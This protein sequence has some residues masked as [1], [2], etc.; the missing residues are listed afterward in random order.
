MTEYS[1]REPEGYSQAPTSGLESQRTG[2]DKPPSPPG[3][4]PIPTPLLRPK[5]K[6]DAFPSSAFGPLEPAAAA[7]A[8]ITRAPFGLAAQ[9]VLAAASLA[10][11]AH[12]N[13]ETLDAPKPLSLFLVSVAESGER[14]TACDRLAL[15]GIRRFEEAREDRFAASY[16][17]YRDE[18]EVFE[19][20]RRSILGKRQDA[21]AQKAD[22]HD[23]GGEP[24]C[25]AA[26]QLLLDDPTMEGLLKHFETSQPSLGI[27]SDEGGQ[28]LCGHGMNADNRIKM[29]T[30]LS[31]LWGGGSINRTRAGTGPSRT[32]RNR[33][34]ACHLMV[35]PRLVEHF[36][37]DESLRDQGLLSRMLLAWPSS[38]I[39]G[40]FLP[41]DRRPD[42]S[43]QERDLGKFNDRIV[44]LMELG[45]PEGPP[46]QLR[47]RDLPLSGEAYE[48]LVD[49]HNHVEPLQR[50][51]APLQNI[52]G[53][54]SK[55]VEQ[56]AR[57]AGV[58]QVFQDQNAPE[59]TAANMANAIELMGWYLGEARRLLEVA[60][61]PAQVKQAEMLRQWLLSSW[62]EDYIDVR[63]IVRRGPSQLRSS[64]KARQAVRLLEED[65]W[66]L[67]APGPRKIDGARANTSWRI[68]RG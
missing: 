28:F 10:G 51:D 55:S 6:A 18:L 33:R 52:R 67:P 24:Q 12:C 17:A 50:Q 68:I 21:T 43:D 47:L 31:T 34:L 25:P 62:Q 40:R 41:S 58:M 38:N 22:L 15:D 44:A 30:A 42:Y 65:L 4:D 61:V 46:R 57:I 39:G 8:E 26:S 49:F 56:A 48:L 35:Q 5:E 45:L 14:K 60:A 2:N 37:A 32:F 16:A 13:V 53:F 23:L 1:G 54:A 59:L 3:S 11:Q 29:A 9:A 7:I 66:L 63:T 27:F 64:D 36:F 20:S 19:A